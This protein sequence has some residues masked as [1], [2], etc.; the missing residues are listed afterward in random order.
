[1]SVYCSL[2]DVCIERLILL[3]QAWKAGRLAR[4]VHKKTTLTSS[5]LSSLSELERILDKYCKTWLFLRNNIKTLVDR[6]E[7]VTQCLALPLTIK[8][9]S[10]S[11]FSGVQLKYSIALRFRNMPHWGKDER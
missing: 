5:S 8:P 1:M 6:H 11:L 9:T 4:G 7:R 2:I 3:V 10:N